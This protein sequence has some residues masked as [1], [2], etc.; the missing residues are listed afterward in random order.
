MSSCSTGFVNDPNQSAVTGNSS[1]S[2]ETQDGIGTSAHLTE[3]GHYQVNVR[4]AT[5]QERLCNTV[6]NLLV[7]NGL[8][9]EEGI[10]YDTGLAYDRDSTMQQLESLIVISEDR[11][12]LGDIA[13]EIQR[14]IGIG[15]IVVEDS[16]VNGWRYSGDILIVLGEDS[17]KPAVGWIEWTSD[18]QDYPGT[19]NVKFWVTIKNATTLI[20]LARSTMLLLTDAGF[21]YE[22]GYSYT[23]GNAYDG[24]ESLQLDESFIIIK[25]EREDLRVVA[26]AMREI[27][28]IEKIIEEDS[29]SSWR[30]DGNIL[31]VLGSD[32]KP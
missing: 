28:G 23:V 24:E 22:V 5:G 20:N 2:N 12:D 19:E 18:Y 8:S 25:E 31:I 7:R 27:L 17:V 21:N 15:T 30:Y 10:K 6:I 11:R 14:I 16:N 13:R 32:Y 3:T 4:N 9:Q 26:E 29:G 1:T